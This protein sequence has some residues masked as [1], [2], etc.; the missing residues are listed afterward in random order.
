MEN[1][2]RW[3]S[4]LVKRMMNTRN[5]KYV[6]KYKILKYYIFLFKKYFKGQLIVESK[7]NNVLRSL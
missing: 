2:T 5:G 4:V 6:S 7:N 3:K 1:N